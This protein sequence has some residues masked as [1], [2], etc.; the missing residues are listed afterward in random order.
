YLQMPRTGF[1]I[2]Q[3]R[4][5]D[6]L[7]GVDLRAR[8]RDRVDPS[9]IERLAIPS[10]DGTAVPLAA[11]G[12]FTYGLEYGV[13]WE[14]DR[15]PTITVQSDAQHPAQGIDVTTRIDKSLAALRQRLP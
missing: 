13:V 4:E 3:F 6:K 14:R 7:I 15:Q 10:Q 2:R 11:L 9:Q 1:T 12:R 5:R 8:E